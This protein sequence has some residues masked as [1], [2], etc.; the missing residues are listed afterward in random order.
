MHITFV[1]TP[2]LPRFSRE[3][4]SPAVTKSDTL[5]YPKWLALA[6]GY[7]LK[8]GKGI[9]LI[10]A[11]A[12]ELSFEHTIDLIELDTPDLIVLDTSTPSINNDIRFA[13]MLKERNKNL[14]IA[15]VGRGASVSYEHVL[16]NSNAIDIV[17]LKEYELTI[18]EIADYLSGGYFNNRENITGI[19]YKADDGLI[20]KNIDRPVLEDLDEIPFVTE[21]YKRFLNIND[22]FYGH[23]LHPLVVLDTSRGCPY[24]CSFCAYPQTFSGHRVRFRSV[25]NVADEF[26]FIKKE[27]PQVKSIML[28]DDTFIINKKRTLDLANELI[29]RGNKIPFD[30]NCRVDIGVDKDFLVKLKQAG[31]RLFCVGFESGSKDVISHMDKNNNKSKDSSYLETAKEF[32]EACQY[33][34]IKIHGC[35]MFGNLNETKNTLKETLNFALKLPLDTAQFYPIMIYPGTSA[36]EEAKSRN[37]INAKSFDDWL[38]IDGMH[39]SVVDLPD[40][41]QDELLA[42]ADYARKRFYLRPKYIWFKLLQS[43]LSFD[44]LKRNIKGFKK[45]VSNLVFG[46]SHSKYSDSLDKKE[47]KRIISIRVLK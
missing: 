29:Y 22:Y 39:R 21:I 23:S 25:G 10:D 18:N 8:N 27:M 46:S 35:F 28:E 40:L 17:C 24:H 38:T 4:R 47:K 12:R 19:A 13:E 20:I 31:A 36:F 41:S 2:F 16:S 34:G 5:Y 43:I 7:S 11:P 15:M 44:E 6:A 14:K 3:S 26:D 45:L 33:A 1:N 37:L 9:N 30:S 32:T 42:F